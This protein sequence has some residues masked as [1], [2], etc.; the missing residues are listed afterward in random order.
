MK[1]LFDDTVF[2]T[3]RSEIGDADTAEVLKA[4]LDDTAGKMARLTA[5]FEVRPLVKREAHSI[6][7]SAATF[8]FDALS[9]LARELEL[10]A[11]TIASSKLRESVRDLRQAFEAI[12]QFALTNLLDTELGIT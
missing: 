8:G 2:H 10:S 12:R 9:R 3:L 11:E 6:K 7:S 4:F 5:N 1:N